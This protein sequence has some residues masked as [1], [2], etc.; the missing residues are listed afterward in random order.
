M[1]K[2]SKYIKSNSY[3]NMKQSD[4]DNSLNVV[5]I[6]DELHKKLT[7]KDYLFENGIYVMHFK[8]IQVP[9]LHPILYSGNL[10]LSENLKTVLAMKG[11]T[12]RIAIPYSNENYLY[13]QLGVKPKNIR[14]YIKNVL[15]DMQ[16]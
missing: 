8:N 5:Q 12:C 13:M 9:A 15:A 1:N 14:D 7:N 11:F 4:L 10:D 2:I 6:C 3:S 16:I